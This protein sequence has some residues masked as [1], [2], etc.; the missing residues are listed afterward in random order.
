MSVFDVSEKVVIVTGGNV[1]IGKA[2]ARRFLQ[3][4]ASVLTC[5]RRDYDAPPA[6]EGVDGVNERIVHMTCDVRE[7]EQVEAVVR[8]TMDEFGRI[9]VLV[10]NAGGSPAADSSTASPRFFAAII[11][12]NLTGL[13]VLSQRVNAIM[14]AQDA[15]GAMINIASIAGLQASPMMAAYGAAKAGVVNVTK[16]FAAE[17]GPKVRVNC[18]APGLILTEGADFLAPTEEAKRSIA[19]SIPLRRIGLPDEI[20]DPVLFFASDASRYVSGSTLLI[21][22]GGRIRGA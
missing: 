16:S 1:G 6:A 3:E 9:D 11:A 2:I 10:N 13:M 5:S 19:S 17:W 22:G 14:Q 8:R 4:G 20:A 7:P 12:I 15:G 18:I 21:D